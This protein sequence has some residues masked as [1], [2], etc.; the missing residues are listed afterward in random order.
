MGMLQYVLSSRAIIAGF[1]RGIFALLT[2]RRRFHDQP[3]REKCGNLDR[4]K[5]DHWPNDP[6]DIGG[7]AKSDS[8]GP[9][10][11]GPGFRRVEQ[12][13]WKTVIMSSITKPKKCGSK[14]PRR[15]LPGYCSKCQVP[16]CLLL[17]GWGSKKPRMIR[18]SPQEGLCPILFH[19]RKE[20]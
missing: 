14:P 20:R 11:Q 5:T 7:R 1:A 13:R 4:L 17:R 18:T 3:D 9:R 15:S 10:S 2:S 8:W 12:L 19:P 6:Q 16:S